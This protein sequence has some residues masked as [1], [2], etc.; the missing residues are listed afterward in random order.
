[1]FAITWHL[2]YIIA[3]FFFVCTLAARMSYG[4]LLMLGIKE[5]SQMLLQDF[6]TDSLP[7]VPWHSPSPGKIL[8]G[9]AAPFLTAAA[10]RILQ[11]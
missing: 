7:I 5:G 3:E 1:M 2:W 11:R 6:A 9:A 8:F 4:T 10:R